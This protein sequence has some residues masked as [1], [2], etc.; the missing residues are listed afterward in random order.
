MRQMNI[1]CV[2]SGDGTLLGACSLELSCSFHVASL[3]ELDAFPG[4]KWNGAIVM[5][6]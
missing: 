4:I 1:I 2:D 3:K 5:K 6:G